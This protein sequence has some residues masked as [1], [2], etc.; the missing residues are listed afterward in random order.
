MDTQ[1]LS[2]SEEDLQIAADI[3]KKGGIVAFPTETVYGLGADAFNQK[4]LKKIYIAKESP[5]NIPM[6][7]H[8]AAQEQLWLVGG[9]IPNIA[10]ELAD[11]F[12]PGPLTMI[13]GKNPAIHKLVNGGLNTVAVRMP[14]HPVAR[15]LIELSGPIAAP[16]A[17]ISGKPSSTKGKHIIKELSGKVD[18]IINDGNVDFGI[19]STIIDLTK[20]PYILLRPGKVTF[21]E[22][23]KFLG[24]GNLVKED[25]DI[26]KKQAKVCPGADYAQYAPSAKV[27]LAPA[28]K[29][30]GFLK[31]FQNGEIIVV[32][33]KMYDY[34]HVRKNFVF[35]SK[36][37][38]AK[39]IFDWFRTVDRFGVKT[40]IIEKVDEVGLGLAVMHRLK[41]AA[42]EIIE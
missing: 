5:S 35:T 25:S 19:E 39:N 2:T 14:K 12:W 34:E 6:I 7:V 36:E 28:D 41:K 9:D 33:K 16:S 29:I 38:L 17:N 37:E 31:D 24:E 20:C 30:D 8:I 4:A 22:L 18:A 21:E 42:N 32:A 10:Y 3:I 26:S 27:I 13:I 11:E 40:V 15:K 23:E 1:V